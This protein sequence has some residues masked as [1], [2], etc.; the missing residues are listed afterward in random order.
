MIKMARKLHKID[1]Q[2]QSA[3]RLASRI[4]LILRGKNKVEYLPHLD[5]GDLVQVT[6]ID[7]LKFS[8]K[9]IGQKKY[10]SYSGYPGGLKTKKMADLSAAQILKKAV[11]QMLPPNKHRVNLLKRLIITASNANK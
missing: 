2:G 6:N 4:A 3:G 7:K 11:K 5:I 10:H 9:K 8:G 1:A